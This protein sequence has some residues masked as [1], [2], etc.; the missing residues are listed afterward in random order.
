[1]RLPRLEDQAQS[2][3]GHPND[4]ETR[5]CLQP[6]DQR[7]TTG[8]DLG[9]NP[10]LSRFHDDVL[11]TRRASGPV[12][13][14]GARRLNPALTFFIQGTRPSE[15]LVGPVLKQA[16]QLLPAGGRRVVV[17]AGSQIDRRNEDMHVGGAA[18]VMPQRGVGESVQWQ[19]AG[20]GVDEAIQD[21][22]QLSRAR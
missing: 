20:H 2:P 14:R 3:I 17:L 5:D 9:F 1:M 12:Q 11:H 22:I 13:I 19:T 7:G 21:L 10:V 18:A 15:L 8:H 4:V 16:I 6:L